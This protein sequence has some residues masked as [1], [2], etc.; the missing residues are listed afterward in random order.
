MKDTLEKTYLLYDI[1]E[2]RKELHVLSNEEE[3]KDL[4]IFVVFNHKVSI[5]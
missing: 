1:V 2:S 3:I 5:N 4:P